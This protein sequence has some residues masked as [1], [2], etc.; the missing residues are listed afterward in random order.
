MN[1]VTCKG[2][3][4]V[5]DFLGNFKSRRPTCFVSCVRHTKPQNNKGNEGHFKKKR[6]FFVGGRVD[7]SVRAMSMA[8]PDKKCL[9]R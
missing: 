4:I 9:H 5:C 7:L 2:A 3:I 8:G 6:I 1:S